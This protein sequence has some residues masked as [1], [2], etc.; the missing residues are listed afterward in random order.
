MATVVRKKIV[1][2]AGQPVDELEEQV[3]QVREG[4]MPPA[5]DWTGGS[6]F[7]PRKDALY[8]SMYYI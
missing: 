1:K 5:E 4:R 3:A 6:V 8:Q 7:F 2:D